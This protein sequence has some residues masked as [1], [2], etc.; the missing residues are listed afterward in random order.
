MYYSLYIKSHCEVPDYEDETS[1]SSKEEAAKIFQ[2]KIGA[3]WTPEMLMEY[4]DAPRE[5]P[6]F[7]KSPDT[8]ISFDP[9]LE[10]HE[11]KERSELIERE[12]HEP[13]GE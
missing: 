4:I 5:E 2:K 13:S 11:Q 3:D 1:A 10:Y 9:F 6:S 12:A 7:K 8:G